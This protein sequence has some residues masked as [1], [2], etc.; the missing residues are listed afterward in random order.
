MIVK[1]RPERARTDYRSGVGPRSP[2]R[3][4]SVGAWMTE[5]LPREMEPA[6]GK[7]LSRLKEGREKLPRALP[8][9]CGS[10]EA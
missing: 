4:R 5:R 6:P 9:N 8:T 3:I 7:V 2:R 10:R 1:A